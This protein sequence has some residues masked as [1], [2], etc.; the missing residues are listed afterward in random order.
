MLI[1]GVQ[2]FTM[3]DYPGKSAAIVFAAGCQMRCGFCHNPEFVLP[4]KIRE[5]QPHF[6]PLS[7]VIRFLEERRGLLDGVVISGGEPTLAPD[8]ADII[9]SIRALGFLI[10]L[11]TNGARPD[12][13]RNLLEKRLV[14]YVAMDIKT[15]PT[16]YHS[17]VGTKI[18]P[19]KLKE[20]ITLIKMSGVQYEFRS[21]L[22][23]E[24]HTPQRL[25]AMREALTGAET[26]YLQNFRPRIT[27]QPSFGGLHPF[28]SDEMSAI[29]DD[30]SRVV[31]HVFIR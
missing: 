25:A 11:D 30:C 28:S 5:L 31:S 17:L 7:A 13:I 12:V 23:K 26:W 21:T 1:S 8:L 9:H 27:L 20:S 19:T 6:I 16:E 18:E 3:L 24:Y 10:K 2:P 22:I 14:N 4:E 29:R 15:D